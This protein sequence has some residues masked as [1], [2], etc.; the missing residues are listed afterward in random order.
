MKHIFFI[1]FFSSI[2][3][4]ANYCIQAV[5]LDR[6]NPNNI[7]SRLSNILENFENARVEE[8]GSYLVLRVGDF[9]SY[10]QALRD[11]GNVKRYYSDAY[12]R[13]CDFDLSRVI[14]PNYTTPVKQRVH[15][16]TQK[17][18]TTV[19]TPEKRVIKKQTYEQPKPQNTV[20]SNTLWQDC[21]KCF[22]PIYLEEEES[23]PEENNIQ[24]VEVKTTK[25]VLKQ[26]KKVTLRTDNDFWVEA[27]DMDTKSS[28]KESE[29]FYDPRY[30]PEIDA[31]KY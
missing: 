17:Y 28:D 25:T 3:A 4:F 30:Y 19:Q 31:N 1:L 11:I 6:F 16:Q 18:T 27:V 21:Q 7:S 29:D 10:S 9:N 23:E 20:Y 14:Y 26:K 2:P 24:K 8:R 15:T 22:A 12:I 13:K 5:T